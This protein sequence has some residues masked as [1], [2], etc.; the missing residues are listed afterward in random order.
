MAIT[1]DAV[2]R[3]FAVTRPM[4]HFRF[5][6]LKQRSTSNC[7]HSSR[8]AESDSKYD[9][10]AAL[11]EDFANDCIEI[12][13]EQAESGNVTEVNIV[14][15]LDTLAYVEGGETSHDIVWMYNPMNLFLDGTATLPAWV[16]TVT[17]GVDSD[18]ST[19]VSMNDALALAMNGVDASFAWTWNMGHGSNT[20]LN[21]T[22]NGVIDA[23]MTKYAE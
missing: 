7:S 20:P 21:T 12:V 6:R 18:S 1:C 16:W 10:F 13:L 5:A 15:V 23:M 4:P 2:S 3:S 14:A 8:Y 9:R 17:G 11:Y 22:Q 19:L